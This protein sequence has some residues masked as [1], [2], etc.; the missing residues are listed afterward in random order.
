M[1]KLRKGRATSS[2]SST[3]GLMRFFDAESHAPKL[4]PQ[5]VLA[6]AAAIAIIWIILLKFTG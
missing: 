6:A 4:S 2:P 1:V 5:F 3:I